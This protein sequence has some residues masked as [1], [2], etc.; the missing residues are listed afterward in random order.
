MNSEGVE[1]WNNEERLTR[2][3]SPLQRELFLEQ[4]RWSRCRL[5][6]WLRLFTAFLCGIFFLVRTSAVAATI[7]SDY[8]TLGLITDD[9]SAGT[10]N[11]GAL[12]D[13]FVSGGNISISGAAT[14]SLLSGGVLRVG[15]AGNFTTI[16]GGELTISAAATLGTISGGV[17]KA[18]GT[19]SVLRITGG[20]VT[21]SLAGS[22]NTI[23]TLSGG[24]VIN[25]TNLQVFS[26][27]YAG[28][29][30]GNGSLEKVSG[31]TLSLS[32]NNVYTGG[33][34]LSAGIIN[35]NSATALGTG[36]VTFSGADIDNSSSS[37]ITLSNNNTQIWNSSFTF[38]GTNALNLG[39]GNVV[40]GITP[41]INVA[42]STLTVGGVIS[43]MSYGLVKLG[44]G[45]LVLTGNNSYSGNT[46]ISAGIL[47][48]GDS[49]YSGRL[50]GSSQIINSGTLIFNR[51]NTLTQGA[52]FGSVISG[53]GVVMQI[54]A[55]ALTLSGTN[56]FS[57][58]FNLSAGQVNLNSAGALGV[59]GLFVIG[60]G[61]INNS[62][63]AVVTLSA[64][65]PELWNANVSFVG[66]NSLH[67][68]AGAVTMSGTRTVTVRGSLEDGSLCWDRS[69]G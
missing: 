15:K 10:V 16:S 36:T 54:G 23:G 66:G 50:S 31:G 21:F 59:G 12:S 48:V 56:T 20:T 3:V 61:A 64:N 41:T 30:S 9:I 29:M 47:Q 25:Y 52:D 40:L 46:T 34:K 11:G 45:T 27:S 4:L 7:T 58:G 33:T 5:E 6:R 37:V 62:S 26:G 44:A 19:A 39:T 28:Q 32:G 14:V 49:G 67:L 22:T 18:A 53:S 17:V 69:F 13:T 60:G 1:D 38:Q 57:G 42:A 63:A 2:R 55:G 24:S 43:G 65:I 68:G 35:I 8:T 51:A